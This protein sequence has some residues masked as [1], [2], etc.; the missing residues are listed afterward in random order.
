MLIFGLSKSL[1]LSYSVRQPGKIIMIT[2]VMVL[3]VMAVVLVVVMVVAV[4]VLRVT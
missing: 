3:V 1:S 4:I 2:M